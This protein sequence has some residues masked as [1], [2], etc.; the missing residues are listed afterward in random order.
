MKTSTTDLNEALE[1]WLNR[2]IDYSYMPTYEKVSIPDEVY[3]LLK[4]HYEFTHP[5]P[6][7]L[8]IDHYMHKFIVDALLQ[9][10]LYERKYRHLSAQTQADLDLYFQSSPTLETLQYQQLF[11]LLH[12][13]E[14]RAKE[15]QQKKQELVGEFDI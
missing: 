3:Q 13:E 1:A 14:D 11:D 6:T 9:W 7:N 5:G 12:A 10:M 15:E 8:P 2:N 4:E